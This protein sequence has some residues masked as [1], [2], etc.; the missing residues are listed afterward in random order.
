MTSS[1]KIRRISLLVLLLLAAWCVM[2]TTHELGH[3][4]CGWLSGGRLRSADLWP[5]HLPY[6]IF[7][8]D[9]RP[10]ITLWGG[11]LLGIALPIVFAAMLRRN[12]AWFIAHFC[13]VA[14]GLYLAT[15]WIT[16]DRELDTAKLLAHGASP[17]S[18]GIYCTLTL[19]AGYFGFRRHVLRV[20]R[21]TGTRS[22][23]NER[24][25]D[26]PASNQST[27]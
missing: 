10:L 2:V 15:A 12:W 5:W 11:P 26:A 18:I 13:V 16:G 1:G 3:V 9:P 27:T 8:P 22:K 20:L 23:S 24:I 19:V 14:N 4:V 21:S 17:I 6:S 25:P 7:D